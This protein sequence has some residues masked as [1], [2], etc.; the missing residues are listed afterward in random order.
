ME[1]LTKHQL[2]LLTILITFVTSIGTSIISFTLLSEAPVEVTQTINRVV[3]KTI[4]K[5]VP[6]EGKTEKIVTTV[7]VNED[8]RILETISKS[9]K[10]IVRIMTKGADGSEIFSG[11]G[12]VVNNNGVIATDIRNYN[13][14]FSYSIYFNDGEV[15]P[16]G[17][18]FLDEKNNL[19]FIESIIPKTRPTKYVFSPAN[20]GNSDN[21]KIGQTIVAVSGKESNAVSIGRIKQLGFLEDKKTVKYILSDI[22]SSRVYPASPILNLSGEIVG[23]EM[24]SSDSDSQNIYLPINILKNTLP[25][26]FEKFAQ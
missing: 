3:E 17:E 24:V 21:L 13:Q 5:V 19:M 26:V 16:S 20:L 8:D 2:I 7:V 23:L 1:D 12:I 25:S 22:S 18:I 11:F 6:E 15:L 14:G 10:S 9:E 4:E